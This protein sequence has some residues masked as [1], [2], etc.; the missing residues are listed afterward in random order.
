MKRTAV[1]LMALLC[2][3]SVL[4][5]ASAGHFTGP[6]HQVI[7]N[8]EIVMRLEKIE[9]WTVVTPDTMEENMALLTRDGTPEKEVRRRFAQD[10]ILAEAYHDGLPDGRVR[11]QMFEDE[12]TRSV[13]NLADLSKKQRT[14]LKKELSEHLFQ[15]Y[16]RLFNIKDNFTQIARHWSM[17]GSVIAY[18]PAAYESGFF[19]LRYF[20]GRAYL[21]TYTQNTPASSKKLLNGTHTYARAGTWTDLMGYVPEFVGKAQPAAADLTHA[22]TLIL[23]A[24]SG[25]Y[26]FAG[27]TEKGA[28]V[29]VACGGRT[30]KAQV[31]QD[32]QYTARILLAPGDNT[33]TA[34]AAK[35][36]AEG[37]TLSRVIRADDGMAALELTEYL[38]GPVDRQKL[39]AAGKASPG[40]R[41]TIRID[42]E[43]R[44]NLT[45]GPDG[46]FAC[47]LQA[48]DWAEHELEITASEEGLTDCTARFTFRPVYEDVSKGIKAFSK[49]LD[50]DV[51]GKKLS[52]DPAG[53]TG[54]KVKMEVYTVSCQRQDG[55]LILHA[56][57][58]RDK[59]MPVIL[60]CPDYLDD[61]IQAKMILTVYG[62]VI[63]PSRTET[64]LPRIDVEYLQYHRTVYRKNAW[65]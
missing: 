5:P 65:W 29:T 53:Y 7:L 23:N 61:E 16:L 60:V 20:N 46:G 54:R 40:A 43:E 27:G 21:L 30:E 10:H 2:L 48:E 31:D 63:E 6:G 51:T 25:R 22:E 9:N 4:L 33:V 18:P 59:N 13:W 44:E 58:S 19:T 1:F 3:W 62:T 32:G 12:K 35:A 52:A 47:T 49:V 50:K 24:H 45:A 26:L 56:N 28:E 57:I 55:R 15:G 38:S 17:W 41:V 34:S 64:A 14:S 39:K 36:K 11:M 37:S 8:E 42:G